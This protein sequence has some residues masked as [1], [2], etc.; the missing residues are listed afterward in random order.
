MNRLLLSIALVA[1]AALGIGGASAQ[2]Y[3]NK[4]I[5]IIV[6][7]APGAGADISARIS[8][9]YMSRLLGVQF[10]VENVTGAGGTTGTTR[11][12]RSAPDGYTI[13]LGHMGTHAASVP[14][15]PN[16][17]YD[18]RVDFE[19]IGLI[20][21]Q[22][23]VLVTRR[24]F[25]ANTLQEFVTYAK[26]NESKL[27]LSHAGVGSV[28]FTGCLLLNAAIG[29]KPTAV[30]FSGTA[31]AMNAILGSQV[32]YL[33]DTV[34][35]A[36]PQYNADKVKVLAIAT[37]KRNSALPNV[38]TSAEG[39]VPAFDAAPFFG[40]FV[41]K[42]TPKPIVDKLADALDKT[43]D[44]E[45]A[46]KRLHGLGADIPEKAQRGP[47]GLAALV[48]SEIARLTPI[49]APYAVKN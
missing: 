10:V 39:G 38:P 34:L 14:L 36:V 49:L 15:Y 17:A 19:P 8:G 7:F 4:P 48:R 9:E 37:S 22:P 20:V 16:L 31:P 42:G 3:P 1:L 26:A 29:I 6:P 24:D 33:C 5:T 11:S 41:P 40:L 44:N 45:D 25:P 21:A 32:D 23:I 35:G 30:P 12:A 18:P 27:N 28:S 2:T 47:A 13:A 46:R 43:L